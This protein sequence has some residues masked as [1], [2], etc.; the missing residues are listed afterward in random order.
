[1][2]STFAT[3]VVSEPSRTAFEA[4][5]AVAESPG[6]VHNPLF[7]YGRTGAGKSHLLQAIHQRMRSH[8]ARVLRLSARDLIDRMI[9]AIRCDRY[10]ALRDSLRITTALL[11]DDLRFVATTPTTQREL[12]LLIG[13]VA[14]SGVQVVV[15]SDGPSQYVR[16][17]GGFAAGIGYPTLPARAEILR[18]AAMRQGIVIGEDVLG[19]IAEHTTGDPRRLLSAFAMFGA[20]SLLQERRHGRRPPDHLS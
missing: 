18:R 14:A 4:A 16:R 2:L 12:L 19:E 7:L 9:D 5:V 10:A 1:M 11:I 13:E 15:A 3:F 6:R 20:R 8:R 17:L